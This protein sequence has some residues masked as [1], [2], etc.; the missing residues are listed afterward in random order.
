[1]DPS[2]SYSDWTLEITRTS[3]SPSSPRTSSSQE[4][5][6]TSS[7]TTMDQNSSNNNPY[8]KI[9]RYHVHRNILAVGPRHSEYF[10]AQFQLQTQE[11]HTQTS[12]IEL[13]DARAD[14]FPLL[15]DFLYKGSSVIPENFT[16]SSAAC[17]YH[18]SEYFDMPELRRVVESYYE[19]NLTKS[20]LVEYICYAQDHHADTLV[21]IAV[22][23]SVTF[24]LDID[25]QTACDLGP[26]LLL[27]ILRKNL[28]A[29]N[30]RYGFHTSKLVANCCCHHASNLEEDTFR[31]LSSTE[32]LPYMDAKAAIYLLSIDARWAGQSTFTSSLAT[33]SSSSDASPPE[34]QQQQEVSSL[35]PLQQRCT[36]ALTEKW[37]LIRAH[38]RDDEQL[39]NALSKVPPHILIDILYKATSEESLNGTLYQ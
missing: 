10:A 8:S 26:D 33:A 35:T 39:S 4:S 12:R 2:I 38:L 21:K 1:M 14:T 29:G 3:S 22:N 32:I 7:A 17:L 16:P 15:L 9:D 23:K 11:Q 20:T 5:S 24:L 25:S 13:D 34:Q 28:Q 36:Q 30:R 19:K 18:L 37:K 6:P 31:E 27:Q